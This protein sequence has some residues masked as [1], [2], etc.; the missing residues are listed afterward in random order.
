[1]GLI[2]QVPQTFF[3]LGAT[4]EV[5]AAIAAFLVG[6]FGLKVYNY[7]SDRKYY[8]F[9][10]AFFFIS[11]SF[12]AGSF[13][14][15]LLYMNLKENLLD[16]FKIIDFAISSVYVVLIL[17]AYTLLLSV[18]SDLRNKR[19]VLFILLL[20]NVFVF[21]SSGNEQLLRN[22]F[23][24]Q[25]LIILFVTSNYFENFAR[26]T[27]TTTFLS[28]ISFASMAVGHAQLY[29]RSLLTYL[30]PVLYMGGYLFILFGYLI[31]LL[32][33]AR[34]ALKRKNFKKRS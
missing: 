15:L 8:W 26:K 7:A 25:F 4:F 32:S 11:I 23:L 20:A 24:V 22:F 18:S 30:S 12:F 31:L 6:F 5:F 16:L 1:M 21:A 10:L 34:L 9:S 3:A 17:S 27:N 2:S 14:H 13:V 19:L 29:A 33:M 28:F